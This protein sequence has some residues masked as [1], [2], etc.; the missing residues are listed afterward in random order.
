MGRYAVS[1]ESNDYINV[2]FWRLVGFRLR[3]IWGKGRSEFVGN[4]FGIPGYAHRVSEIV[5]L[6]DEY[7]FL[8]PNSKK[9]SA[10]NQLFLPCFA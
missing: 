5:L 2:C 6:N 4:E 9:F 8:G 10:L 3:Y 1:V 7:V